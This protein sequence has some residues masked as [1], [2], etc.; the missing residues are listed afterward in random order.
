MVVPG[1]GLFCQAELVLCVL[2]LLDSLSVDV[3]G[4]A[5][6]GFCFWS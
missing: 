1:Y 4:R 6:V 2:S 5:S 3:W